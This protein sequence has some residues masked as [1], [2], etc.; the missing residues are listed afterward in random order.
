MLACSGRKGASS[1]D[2]VFEKLSR[3]RD[4]NEAKRYYTD[5]TVKALEEAGGGTGNAAMRLLPLFDERTQWEEV[6]KRVEGGRGIIRI[7][8]T[9][10]PVEN[11]VGFEMEFQ[12]MKIGDSWKVDLEDEVRGAMAARSKGSAAAYIR[13]LTRGY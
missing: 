11:M 5:G 7:R 2:G 3:A 6:S 9:A 8:Y 1:F 12:V 4:Y 10:H 13:S